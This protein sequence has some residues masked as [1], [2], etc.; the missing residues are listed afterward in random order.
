MGRLKVPSI[1]YDN[2]SLEKISKCG[3]HAAGS[4]VCPL[5]MNFG[6]QFTFIQHM[7]FK[8]KHDRESCVHM[9]QCPTYGTSPPIKCRL[10]RLKG[11]FPQLE[12]LA[13][14]YA[15]LVR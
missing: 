6:F 5:W 15:L 12:E 13:E 11:F 4:A 8:M 7:G 1:E 2:E 14:F 10:L 9:I 3:D